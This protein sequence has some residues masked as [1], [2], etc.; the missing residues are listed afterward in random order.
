MGRTWTTCVCLSLIAGSVALGAEKPASAPPVSTAPA[1]AAVL[2]HRSWQFQDAD[3]EYLR[4]AIPQ[5]ALQGM[6]RI[7]LSHHIVMDAE[8]LWEGPGAQHRLDLVRKACA[9]AQ[10]NGL[11]VDL[12]THELSGL[13]RDRFRGPTGGK[14]VLSPELWAWVTAKYEK[15]FELVPDISGLVLTFAETDFAVYR[16]A[17]SSDLD[18]PHRLAKL[19]EVMSEVCARHGKLLILRT[20]VYE[21]QDMQFMHAALGLVAA[22]RQRTHNV[23]VMTK[24]VP[25]DWTPFYPFDSLLGNVAGLPQVVEIDLGQEFTGLSKILHCEVDYV[26][27]VMD[28]ARGKGVI[29]AVARVEREANQRALGTPNEVNIHAFCRLLHDPALSA[30]ALWR[31][32]SVRRYGPKAAPHVIRALRRTFDITNLTLFPLEQWISHHSLLPDWNYA[33]GHITS[34]QNAKWIPGPRQLAARDELL[35][36]TADTLIKIN[37]EK[38]LALKF[39]ELS[40]ADLERARPDLSAADYQELK[41]YLE[42]GR[43]NVEV[44]RAHNLAM[45]TQLHMQARK[46]AGDATPEEL[47]ALHAQV[48]T[49]LQTLRQWAD[50]MQQRYG[51]GTYPGDPDSIRAFIDDFIKRANQQK[52]AAPI[53]LE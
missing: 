6:N 24:C 3:W 46:T 42:L 11:Q 15:L 7:Q 32:W 39:T 36:P 35:R 23:V 5:A 20:F 9:L 21:P 18:P 27:Y 43:D 10:A 38:D 13:P 40:L 2:P 30:N 50:T 44:F 8:Q 1:Q 33:H 16:N 45:F 28:Y 48:E 51:K 22:A 19:I 25:H 37:A 31:E 4:L 41:R 29:G 12:W 53:K 17:V 52:Q 14:P 49:H 34:R 47:T 26:Q